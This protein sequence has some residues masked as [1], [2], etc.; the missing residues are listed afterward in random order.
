MLGPTLSCDSVGPASSLAAFC[1]T[2]VSPVLAE[3][4]PNDHIRGQRRRWPYCL[5]VLL[6][7]TAAVVVRAADTP[8][9]DEQPRVPGIVRFISDLDEKQ[10]DWEQ[11][12]HSG[13]E[14]EGAKAAADAVVRIGKAAHDKENPYT[15]DQ[16]KAD[17]AQPTEMRRSLSN[18]LDLGRRIAVDRMVNDAIALANQSLKGLPGGG[19]LPMKEVRIVDSGS[20]G[21]I[22]RD[23]DLTIFGGDPVKE[24]AFFA[25][26]N[27]VAHD[28]GFRPD[29]QPG[30]GIRIPELDIA[31]HPGSQDRPFLYQ[32][33]DVIDYAMRYGAIVE[34]QAKNP[35]AYIGWGSDTEVLGRRVG[36]FKKG[37]VRMRVYSVA[38]TG[39]VTIRP[40]S[41][42]STEAAA[43]LLRMPVEKTF[44]PGKRAMN[45]L[46]NF[47][48]AVNHEEQSQKAQRQYKEML[49]E[50][51][52][53]KNTPEGKGVKPPV[54]PKEDPTQGPLKY[55]ERQV[56]QLME[57]H[58]PGSGKTFWN[59]SPAEQEALVWRTFP[60]EARLNPQ[61]QKVVKALANTLANLPNTLKG[62]LPEG[63]R[64]DWETGKALVFL[65][66]SSSNAAVTVAQEMLYPSYDAEFV[67]SMVKTAGWDALPESQ[68]KALR[69]KLE[70]NSR[71][72]RALEAMENLLGMMW[73]IER[74]EL[75]DY[76]P[77]GRDI[78]KFTIDQILEQARRMQPENP[79]LA[80]ILE[81]SA[82]FGIAHQIHASVRDVT[83]PV[84]Q[85]AGDEM[86]RIRVKLIQMVLEQRG[87]LTRPAGQDILKEGSAL[88]PPALV[89]L[90]S[91]GQKL[92]A[93]VDI[94]RTEKIMRRQIIEM[95]TPEQQ[96][97]AIELLGVTSLD[98]DVEA[99]PGRVEYL[100][101][102]IF[103]EVVSLNTVLDALSLLE[104]W[105]KG[106]TNEQLE[107]QFGI[108]VLSRVHWSI[109]LLIG[110]YQSWGNHESWTEFKK[111]LV[112]TPFAMAWPVVGEFKLLV[113]IGVGLVK[114]TVTPVF[115]NLDEELIDNRY[116]SGNQ[117][118]ITPAYIVRSKDKAGKDIL[119]VD[120]VK[121]FKDK[122]KTW[123]GVPYD[124]YDNWFVDGKPRFT[125]YSSEVEKNEVIKAHDAYVRALALWLRGGEPDARAQLLARYGQRGIVP[126]P[127]R[128][129]ADALLAVVT[130]RLKAEVDTL[131]VD[132][133][134]R[135][136]TRRG[137]EG[138]DRIA[139]GLL[140][141]YVADFM[142]G[143]ETLWRTQLTRY[144]LAMRQIEHTAAL[145]DMA[146]MAEYA[147]AHMEP[148]GGKMPAFEVRVGVNLPTLDWDYDASEVLML[149]AEVACKGNRPEN[150][151]A[152]ELELKAG[153]VKNA[154][155]KKTSTNKPGDVL[156]SPITVTAYA[157]GSDKPLATT[158]VNVRVRVPDAKPKLQLVK[159]EEIGGIDGGGRVVCWYYPYNAKLVPKTWQRGPLPHVGMPLFAVYD[160]AV[161]HGKVEYTTK[162]GSRTYR[163]DHYNY[164]EPVGTWVVYDVN[165]KVEREKVFAGGRIISVTTYHPNGKPRKIEKYSVNGE[166]ASGTV[167]EISAEGITWLKAGFTGCA[168]GGVDTGWKITSYHGAYEKRGLT[169][170]GNRPAYVNV[171]EKGVYADGKKSGTWTSDFYYN[172]NKP[173]L[174]TAHSDIQYGANGEYTRLVEKDFFPGGQVKSL[175]DTRVNADG[176]RV[177]QAVDYDEAGKVWYDTTTTTEAKGKE[178]VKRN[179]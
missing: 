55:A 141:L 35:E 114:V 105:Q 63:G 37:T 92:A 21:N 175:R 177:R 71:P 86:S 137:E 27:Q 98:A 176:S 1:S 64:I 93:E 58:H 76:K 79:R 5:C 78:G 129:S 159:H 40:F 116:K 69:V 150:M 59:L 96:A 47:L 85:A 65:R 120:R 33:L 57:I 106:A 22:T 61:Q 126:A 13:G 48:Q 9:S 144:V 38:P 112:F 154:D 171:V 168:W 10:V 83:N 81:L 6:C 146:A 157:K 75:P 19:R 50:Y 34:K 31:M 125:R 147:T 160:D 74:A 153:P 17:L 84:R 91:R 107:Q 172:P 25:A 156:I 109:G 113:D 12:W 167:E 36:T 3:M 135:I 170:V 111:T 110:G 77:F 104:S 23:L 30:S 90:K 94:S 121:L 165:G 72:G 67:E 164:G 44:G 138:K 169:S 45:M 60:D 152:V 52:K 151:P 11:A 148:T 41:A 42:H 68:R 133:P 80:E 158:T 174:L 14:S 101:A 32:T 130:A 179:K 95:M 142:G 29:Y 4:R 15:R 53:I 99:G 43:A 128:G 46:G 28:L 49:A 136:S 149:S 132:V 161:I 54:E 166:T 8:V 108:A 88:K 162:D 122:F 127:L 102:R 20:T 51:E 103:H 73:T 56:N 155:P 145:T 139:E 131:L 16:L 89:E 82:R 97:R 118:L 70:E 100:K 140:A 24:H 134:T 66:Q 178:T 26:L 173:D 87:M 124:E 7:L 62:Q 115:N 123:T 119:E 18:K 143:L 163:V 117:S 39:T 2:G